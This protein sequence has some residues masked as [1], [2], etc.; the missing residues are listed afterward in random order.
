MSTQDT[1]ETRLSLVPLGAGD[2]ID[3]AV[4]FYRKNFLTFIL[5]A[6]PP[7][8][9]GTVLSVGWTML[10]RQ[11]FA[12]GQ[13]SSASDTTL[14]YLFIWFGSLLIWLVEAIGTLIVMG[15][16]ARNFVRHLLFGEAISLRETYSNVAK[17]FVGLVAASSM[18]GVALGILGFI[19]FY[20][21]FLTTAVLIALIVGIFSSIPVVAVILSVVVGI[22]AVYGG[23]W[24]YFLVASR[25]AYVPQIMLVEG[26]GIF[27]AV[28]RSATLAS[29]NVRRLMALFAF[30]IMATLSALALLYVPLTW[31][32]WANG[33]ELSG[34]NADLVPAWLEIGYSLIWQISF[35]LLSPI[36]TIGLCL[37]YVDERVRSEGYDI[38]LMAARRLGEIPSVPQTYVNPLQPALGNVNSAPIRQNVPRVA[39]P[40]SRSILGLD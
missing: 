38:E 26:Q 34:F 40:P 21:I 31:Y 8:V 14:Y 12:P 32:A 30:T 22:A 23:S 7:V 20:L 24:L 28:A 39:T 29:G 5:M 18:I 3:R 9:A 19:F 17:R 2:L 16:A 11:I 33:I 4:R 35:I 15:G 25:F 10:G 13:L 37:L 27:S 36:W 1:T 6:A